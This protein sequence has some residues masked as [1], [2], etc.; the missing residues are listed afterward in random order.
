MGDVLNRFVS[1][2]S[3]VQKTYAILSLGI[4]IDYVLLFSMTLKM[5]V[6][7]KNTTLTKRTRKA[8]LT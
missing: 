7:K 4:A 6:Q 5:I 8:G 1:V 2:I 3:A